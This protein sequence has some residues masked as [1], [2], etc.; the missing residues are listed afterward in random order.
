VLGAFLL[1]VSPA[2]RVTRIRESS[3]R[4]RLRYLTAHWLYSNR[5]LS[6][7][8]A[9]CGVR[10]Y[11]S[12]YT[13]NS[14]D[15]KKAWWDT[16]Q[17]VSVNVTGTGRDAKEHRSRASGGARERHL[18]YQPSADRAGLT[19]KIR[20]Q[21]L[22]ALSRS[23]FLTGSRDVLRRRD[24]RWLHCCKMVGRTGVGATASCSVV[25]AASL[26]SARAHLRFAS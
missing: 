4:D 23:V 2:V 22:V 20:C 8:R 5:T 26:V 9:S 10:P 12:V 17:G 21:N 6:S 11:S 25:V 15:V 7:A 18:D 16:V 13:L 1:S 3:K 19:V 24:G 14:Q